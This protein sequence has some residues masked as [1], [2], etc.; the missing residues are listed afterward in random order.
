M[1]PAYSSVIYETMVL[2][3][4]DVLFF[5]YLKIVIF[6]ISGNPIVF[7]LSLKFLINETFLPELFFFQFDVLIHLFIGDLFQLL[8]LCII[9]FN[10][11][12][13]CYH[14][15]DS[16]YLAGYQFSIFAFYINI[17]HL[18]VHI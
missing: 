9:T 8:R 10:S 16:Y 4:T 15:L 6:S 11:V 7:V 5:H 1:D 17:A 13:F 18:I 2:L 12:L 14:C 3:E